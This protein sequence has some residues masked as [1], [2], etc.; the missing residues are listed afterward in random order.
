MRTGTLSYL[1]AHNT[2]SN[3]FKER[4]GKRVQN[5]LVSRLEQAARLGKQSQAPEPKD[6]GCWRRLALLGR[7]MDCHS[8]VLFCTLVAHTAFLSPLDCDSCRVRR[9]SAL[10]LHF[11][12][13]CQAQSAWPD[14]NA[15]LKNEQQ[16]LE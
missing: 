12:P 2:H 10:S 1:L 11:L 15:F 6:K 3:V 16:G 13:Q 5:E 8:S 9:V 14:E 7:V 4:V